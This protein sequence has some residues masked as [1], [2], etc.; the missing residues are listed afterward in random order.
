MTLRLRPSAPTRRRRSLNPED[1]FQFWVTVGFIA[2]IVAVIAVFLIA[3]GVGYY[4]DHLK[5]I[6]SVGGQSISPDTWGQRIRLES[7]RL[8][9]EEQRLRTALTQNPDNAARLQAQLADVQSKQATQT[10]AE[11]AAN[12][13][14]DL[15]Y[16]QELAAQSDVTVTDA[17]VDAQETKDASWPEQRHVLAIMVEP[18]AATTGATPTAL[19]QQT[20][21]DNAQK[22][23]AALAS[24]QAFDQVARQ[25]S[26]DASK[27]KGGDLGFIE[28]TD[29]TDPTWDDALFRLDA[30]GTTPVIKGDDGVYRIGQVT[31]IKPGTADPNFTNGAIDKVGDGFYRD[32]LRLE[33]LADKLKQKITGDELAK[34]IDQYKLDEIKVAIN[35]SDP[36]NDVQVKAAHVLY[37]PNH[38]PQNQASLAPDDP[39]WATAKASA[40]KTVDELNGIVDVTQREARFAE[41]AKAESDDKGSGAN[42]GELGTFTRDQMVPAFADP[43]FDNADL[44]PGDIVGPVLSEFGYH[45]ILFEERIPSA[46]DRVGAVKIA[47]AAPGADFAAVAKQYSD[48][49]EAL[50]GG[51]LGWKVGDQLPAEVLTEIQKTATGQTTGS[52]QTAD[53]FYFEKVEDKAQRPPEG[54]PAA[55]LAATAFDTWYSTQK[56]AATKSGTIQTNKDVFSVSNGSGAGA[57]EGP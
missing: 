51:E 4:N 37:S 40:Q 43:L 25:Y 22:A 11:Q 46:T 47:L 36:L 52:I 23:A 6:A 34:P 41:I 10:V 7:Y 24:G 9:E 49:D 42:G 54:Q 57:S 8:A 50:Q 44:K 19:D 2:L 56:D 27:D 32:Q 30:G 29:T 55:Q 3:I 15:T 38:D 17:D 13:L 35:G 45:V 26:T 5:P 39:A 12:D 16:Q 31:E 14:V 48:G 33:A 1:R 18:T 53:A 28:A 20:A 21:Y